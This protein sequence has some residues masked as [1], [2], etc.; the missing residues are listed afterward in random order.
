MNTQLPTVDESE[1]KVVCCKAIGRLSA[2]FSSPRII[3]SL[4]GMCF[5]LVGCT[6]YLLGRGSSRIE[7]PP[8][9]LRA[10]ATHAGADMAIATAQMD[11]E[12]E[13]IYFLDFK[14]GQLTCYVYYPRYAQFGAKYVGNVTEQLAATKGAEYLMVTGRIESPA[15]A[16]N[17]RAAMS[18]CYVV[19]T[20]S[21]QFAAYTVPVN[22]AMET[23]GQLQAGPVVFIGGGEVRPPSAGGTKRTMPSGAAPEATPAPPVPNPP[24]EGEAPKA[25]KKRR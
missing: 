3:L 20:K 6:A 15:A 22:R 5:V 12:N 7:L 19:D 10:T 17:N 23:S 8:E 1:S 14:T 21:G 4:V 16:N 9:I 13:G 18:V 24:A 2:A 25:E 11:N